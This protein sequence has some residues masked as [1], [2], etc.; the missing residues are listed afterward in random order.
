MVRKNEFLTITAFLR[1]FS[2]QRPNHIAICCKDKALTYSQ[3]WLQCNLWAAFLKQ[4]GIRKGDRIAIY[5]PKTFENV[6]VMMAS[7]FLGAI[8]VPIN[9]SLKAEQVAYILQ[10]SGAKLLVSSA[11]RVQSFTF[12]Q[13]LEGFKFIDVNQI[14]FDGDIGA[15]HDCAVILAHDLAA[16]LYTSG[17]TGKPKGV[18][19]SHK[20]LTRGAEIVSEYLQINQQDKLLAVLPFSFDYG[21]NQLMS[22]V[23]KGACCVLLD[24]LLPRDVIKAC[25]KHQITG[26]AAV[27]P[28]WH[29]LAGLNWPQEAT[30]S[31]RYFTNSGGALALPTLKTLRDIFP[32]AKP[33]LMYGLTEAFRSTYLP[34]ALIDLKPTAMGKAV[35]GETI[36][37]LDSEGQFCKPGE[38]GELVHIGDLVTQGYWQ[39]VARTQKRFKKVDI[40]NDQIGVWSGDRVRADEDGILYFISRMDEMIKTSGYRVSPDE[41][42]SSLVEMDGMDEVCAFGIPHPE[43][44]QAI[45]TVVT[46]HSQQLTAES[47]R[48]HCQKHLANYMVPQHIEIIAIM[49][50]NPNGKIDRSALKKKFQ[51]TFAD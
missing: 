44:G 14:E 48:R 36:L 30:E 5:I 22:A 16:I 20:N 50:K 51:T 9:P 23:F 7:M 8:F 19:V 49:P 18:M 4:Q 24:Y 10:H 25:S 33:F 29:S 17:S 12:L 15:D 39:D 2:V 38:T 27:P 6:A 31:L 13:N 47:I 3:L 11:Q 40:A 35:P 32:N 21:L 28:L 37:V 46:T 26:L 45:V 1:Q 42:E 34:P 43:L 41:I